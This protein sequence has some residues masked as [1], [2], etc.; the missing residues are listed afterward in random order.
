[1]RSQDLL[2]DEVLLTSERYISRENK[3]DDL[4]LPLMEFEALAMATNRFSD[5]NMLGQGGFG[6]VYKVKNDSKCTQNLSLYKV[7]FY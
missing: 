1:M 7:S 5:A 3:T 4:E 2:I 6:I